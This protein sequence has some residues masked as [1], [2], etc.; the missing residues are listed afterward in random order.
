MY[1]TLCQARKAVKS[2]KNISVNPE[3]LLCI[4]FVHWHH[5]ELTLTRND[6]L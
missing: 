2:I 1:V 3:N 6:S 5:L 4:S